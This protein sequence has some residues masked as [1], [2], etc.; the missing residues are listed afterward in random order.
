MGEHLA[1]ARLDH[2]A[3]EGHPAVTADPVVVG[4]VVAEAAPK[5]LS[6][7]EAALEF[8]AQMVGSIAQTKKMRK[9]ARPIAPE[10]ALGF[11]AQ[12]NPAD[13]SLLSSCVN[14]WAA[15]RLGK[16]RVFAPT[17]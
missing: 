1:V 6:Q 11:R 10:Q 15:V 3:P 14:L 12:P 9:S 2:L 13:R 5:G 4:L 17:R 8:Q 7:P 16:A